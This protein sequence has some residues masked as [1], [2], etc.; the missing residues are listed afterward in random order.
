MAIS[1]T[2]LPSTFIPA[3]RAIAVSTVQVITGGQCRQGTAGDDPVR[4]PAAT[5]SGGEADSKS[6]AI[7][8][9]VKTPPRRQAQQDEANWKA[10]TRS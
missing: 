1:S 10:C 6:R 2:P 3:I 8:K 7:A 9:P 4:L 5:G